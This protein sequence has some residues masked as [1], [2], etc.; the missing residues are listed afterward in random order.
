MVFVGAAT[1]FEVMVLVCCR[2]EVG[3][4]FGMLVFVPRYGAEDT[5]ILGHFD[6]RI[7]CSPRTRISI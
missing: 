4:V 1:G 7:F 2:L 5:G 3:Y 6:E